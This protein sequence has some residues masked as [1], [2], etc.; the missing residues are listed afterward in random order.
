MKINGCL[1]KVNLCLRGGIGRH[2][3][4]KIPGPYGREGS[5]P[6]SGTILK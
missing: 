6:S 2:M 4:L 3:G 5:S 1:L